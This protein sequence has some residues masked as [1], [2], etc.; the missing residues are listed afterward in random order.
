MISLAWDAAADN[1]AVTEYALYSDS[2][3]IL[4]TTDLFA[5]ISALTANT[6]YTFTLIARDAA[7]NLSPASAPLEVSTDSIDA[8]EDLLAPTAPTNLHTVRKTHG[9]ITLAWDASSDDVA[10]AE[11]EIYD[12]GVWID[13]TTETSFTITNLPAISDH[14]FRVAAIDTSWHLSASSDALH[15]ATNL[16]PDAAA[17]APQSTRPSRATSPATRHL[18][19]V[20]PTRFRVGSR[21]ARFRPR[22]WRSCVAV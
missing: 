18:S 19:T 7:G 14:V 22:A 8:P 20:A 4:T 5:T 9:T 12:N 10:V 2:T 21:L 1:V 15:V 13:W 6:T 16:P 11:Y 3:L 17:V